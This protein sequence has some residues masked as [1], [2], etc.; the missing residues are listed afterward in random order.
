MIT[1]KKDRDCDYLWNVLGVEEYSKLE[2]LIDLAHHCGWW[3]PYK[4]AVILQDRPSLIK[5]DDQNR[6][7]NENG[8]SILYKDGFSVYSWH[9][10][11]VPEEWIENKESITPEMALTWDNVEQRRSAC[12][13]LG[14]DRILKYLNPVSIDTDQDPQ[15]GE[16]LEVEL[17]EMGK[18]RFLRVQC[19]TGRTFAIPVHPEVTTAI[20]ANSWTFGLD[21]D[22]LRQLE[23]RT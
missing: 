17:P 16:L 15:V 14:W 21:I 22:I 6:L 9:G 5:F 10:T 2:G 13:I 4:N 8:P 12:E 7:H 20:Q 3:S 19:G 11:K 18:E 1:N 23:I